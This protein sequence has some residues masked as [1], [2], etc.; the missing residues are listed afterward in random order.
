MNQLAFG[1]AV[2][3]CA[4]LVIMPAVADDY[5]LD[6]F[7]NANMDDTIDEDDVAY[8]EGII[9][10]TNDETELADA[11]YN[12][13]IDEDDITQIELIIAGEDEEITIID[14]ADRVVTVKKPVKSAIPLNTNILETMRSIKATD[15]IIATESNFIEREAIL[16]AEFMDLPK[17]GSWS[18]PDIEAIIELKPEIL[19][20][21]PS[22]TKSKTEIMDVLDSSGITVIGFDCFNPATYREEVEKLGYIFGKEG[23]Y[24]FL[25]FYENYIDTIKGRTESLLEE[26]RPK[27]YVESS[28]RG[29]YYSYGSE[30]GYHEKIWIAGGNNLFGDV[31]AGAVEVDPEEVISRDPD[32]ILITSSQ[33]GYN[34]S[35]VTELKDAR[36]ELLSRS[37]LSNT[38]AVADEDVYVMEERI[39]GGVRNFVGI[40]Y[41]AKWLHQDLF[42]DLDP[43]AIHQEY[44]TRFQGLDYDLSENG[45]FVYPPL[46]VS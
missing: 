24:E 37:E 32:L 34:R 8:V 18:S 14:S 44:L 25:K 20:W 27:V 30:S 9:A 7:G 39:I 10:G 23:A 45:V 16:F 46:E 13:V 33:G 29:P 35:E 26:D 41:M 5:T 6:I 36:D 38:M 3:A 21:Y 11:N 12:G 43:Q 1:L 17:V 15:K 2:L 19:L 40:G 42:E 31:S 28:G 4:M 22:Y